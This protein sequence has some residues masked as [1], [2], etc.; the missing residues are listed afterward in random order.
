MNFTEVYEAVSAEFSPNIASGVVV[1]LA[2]N[3]STKVKDKDMVTEG[4][5]TK[6]INKK[7]W[8]TLWEYSEDEVN[9]I[10]KIRDNW[11]AFELSKSFNGLGGCRKKTLKELIGLESS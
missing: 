6:K 8:D 4:R 7:I 1:A 9:L 11:S 5:F 10:I 2:I 3:L